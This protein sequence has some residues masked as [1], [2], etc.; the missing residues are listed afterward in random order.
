[1]LRFKEY[2]RLRD[3]VP[4]IARRPVSKLTIITEAARLI[5]QLEAAVLNKFQSEGIPKFLQGMHSYVQHL[6]YLFTPTQKVY[7]KSIFTII[8]FLCL[9]KT[10]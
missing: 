5:D 10:H 7:L 8:V 6:Y 4:S 2:Q 3:S 9:F 1:M